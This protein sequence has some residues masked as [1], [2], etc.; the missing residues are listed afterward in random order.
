MHDHPPRNMT[1]IQ[2]AA[3]LVRADDCE[4][5]EVAPIA[6][7]MIRDLYDLAKMMDMVRSGVTPANGVFGRIN[8]LKRLTYFDGA[9][10]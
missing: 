5:R 10:A 7:A 2:V 8:E 1:P 6:A 3:E 4:L 9:D